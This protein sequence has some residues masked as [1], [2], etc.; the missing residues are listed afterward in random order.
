MNDE[1]F[2]NA[3]VL[4]DYTFRNSESGSGILRQ[5]AL[6]Y[7][8]IVLIEPVIDDEAQ[9]VKFVVDATDVDPEALIELFEMLTEHLKAN[10][11]KVV[12]VE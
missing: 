9:E 6:G 7:Q 4:M 1:E 5:V 10:L 11:D 2:E 12:E 3:A 8:P